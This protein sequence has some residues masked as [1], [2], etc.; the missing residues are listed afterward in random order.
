MFNN[1][2]LLREEN[3]WSQE[4]LGELIGRCQQSIANYEKGKTVPDFDTLVLLSEIYDASFDF[5]LDRTC[6]RRKTT[7]IEPEVL[8]DEE[9]EILMYYRRLARPY[10][11][12]VMSSARQLFK[13]TKEFF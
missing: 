12:V 11:D 3:G 5:M 4:K 10:R 8:S 6:V 13:A 1:L 9:R 7:Y 2:K